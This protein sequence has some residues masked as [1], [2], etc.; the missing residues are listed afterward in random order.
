IYVW[1][2]S[3]RVLSVL[4]V[5]LC[6]SSLEQ[7]NIDANSITVSGIS[8]GAAFATQFHVIYSQEIKGVATFAG[9]V[10]YC[11][12]GNVY[13]SLTCMNSPALTNVNLLVSEA[14]SFASDL[15]IDSTS[16]MSGDKVYIF[17]GTEDSVVAPGN[18]PNI[19]EFYSAFSA[20][21][22]TD[23]NIAAEHCQPTN[24]YGAACAHKG[25][26]YINNCQFDG[27]YNALNYLYGN[28]LT[29]PSSHSGSFPGLYDTF[30]QEEFFNNNAKSFSL[31]SSGYLYVP[32]GTLDNPQG[33]WDWWG[34]TGI[35][36][37]AK[38]SGPQPK[39]I[40]AM[41]DRLVHGI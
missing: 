5:A 26:E 20:S 4:A 23:Y 36:N 25:G 3:K 6:Q 19:E 11:A 33:C 30:D 14:K 24:F 17:A 13:T 15:S 34:Y 41:V 7:Y 22:Y 38:N 10:Y 28:S 37:Y 21:I 1:S 27:A 39:G 32:S 29:K 31:D 35:L 9:V 8:S 16:G 2:P 18:G 40:K 12:Y